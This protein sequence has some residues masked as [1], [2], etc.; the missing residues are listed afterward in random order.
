MKKILAAFAALVV[1]VAL[2][3][4]TPALA[5]DANSP[6]PC[7][8]KDAWTEVI[9]HPAETHIEKK[10]VT[11]EVPEVPAVPEVWANFSPNHNQ[12][13]FDGPPSYPNDPRGTWH[14][15]NKIPGGHAGS[16]GV[17]QRDNPGAGR[18]DWFYRQNGRDA[19]PGSPATY[20]DVVVVDKQAWTE[21]I[22]HEAET[23]EDGPTF[24]DPVYEVNI[25][26][27]FPPK[28]WLFVI[29]SDYYTFDITYA[30]RGWEVVF[31]A[32]EGYAFNPSSRYTVSDDGH[33]AIAHGFF[34]VVRCVV[35]QE[36]PNVPET[37]SRCSATKCVKITRDGSGK[38][39]DREVI[40][41]PSDVHEEGL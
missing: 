4:A 32:N 20:E 9:E 29:E 38:I 16:D 18:G 37:E 8:P 41:Y 22:E 36:P 15:H 33:T 23:C 12:G 7:V 3:F 40:V 10:L 5:D 24:I 31:T 28:E 27:L 11:P 21:T 39:V 26:C 14:V 17:Y 1:V 19:I 6:E 25:N 35:P 34:P 30:G 13:P 2:L